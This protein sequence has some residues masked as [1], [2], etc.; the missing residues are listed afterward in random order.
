MQLPGNPPWLTGILEACVKAAGLAAHTG[1]HGPSELVS[2]DR[3]GPGQRLWEV[4]PGSLLLQIPLTAMGLVPT[5]WS[6]PTLGP[7]IHLFGAFPSP[8]R[9]QGLW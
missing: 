1:S 4:G 6:R 2:W 5:S 3:P 8:S 7:S 9:S